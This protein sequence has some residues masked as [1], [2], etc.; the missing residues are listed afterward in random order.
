MCECYNKCIDEQIFFVATLSVVD[1][2]DTSFE[3][4]EICTRL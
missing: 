1:M 2:C 4:N 3:L